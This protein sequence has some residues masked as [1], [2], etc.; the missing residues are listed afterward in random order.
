M[1]YFVLGADQLAV[2]PLE[3]G[4]VGVKLEGL[5]RSLQMGEGI[6]LVLDLAPDEARRLAI[7]LE[8]TAL[9]AEGG[10]VQH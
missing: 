6:E 9:E 2:R 5:G 3:N 1:R 10:S 7:A 4:H 8:R